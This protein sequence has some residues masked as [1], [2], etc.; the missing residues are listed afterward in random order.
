MT[1]R[2]D[3]AKQIDEAFDYRGHV[4][5]TFKD[6]GTIVGYLFNRELTPM[7]GEAYIEIIPKDT[8]E[9]R[10]FQASEVKSVAI[11]GKDYAAP[12]VPKTS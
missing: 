4:T 1:L 10:R 7:K 2:P 9:R 3:V 8:D 11:T 6:G 5:V 12:F